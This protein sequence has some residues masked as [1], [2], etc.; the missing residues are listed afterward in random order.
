ML[1]LE[2]INWNERRIYNTRLFM[3]YNYCLAINNDDDK[4]N[5]SSSRC[6]TD[7]IVFPERDDIGEARIQHTTHTCGT[8][9]ADVT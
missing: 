5:K 2:L 7:R 8:Y 1:Q 3:K 6:R 9:C 4:I